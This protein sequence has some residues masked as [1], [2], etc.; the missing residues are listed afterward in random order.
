MTR[1][2][3]Y[4]YLSIHQLRI[5]INKIDNQQPSIISPNTSSTNE[6]SQQKFQIQY[7]DI[8]SDDDQSG[9]QQGQT[10]TVNINTYIPKPE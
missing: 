3:A 1:Y 7:E 10:I 9:E 5:G 6:T 4:D 8:S 2:A